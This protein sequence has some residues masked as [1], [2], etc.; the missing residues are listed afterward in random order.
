MAPPMIS[1]E[2]SLR[3]RLLYLSICLHPKE[4]E[5]ETARGRPSGIA[6]TIRAIS[7]M[8]VSNNEIH[9]LLLVE[10]SK[11][12]G[13]QSGSATH[14]KTFWQPHGII[15]V[16]SRYIL[17]THPMKVST[18][19]RIPRLPILRA[20]TSSFCWSRVGSFSFSTFSWIHPAYVLVPTATTTALQLPLKTKV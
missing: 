8:K 10:S 4:R 17:T 15:S 5:M 12:R 9:S 13:L 3:T 1:Q 14:V 16:N 11:V 19:Q 2:L 7:T 6:A 18:E 20:M